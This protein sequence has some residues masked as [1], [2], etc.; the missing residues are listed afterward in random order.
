M[1]RIEELRDY[2]DEVLLCNESMK[3]RRGGFVHLYGVAQASAVLAKKRG[4]DQ[5]LAVMAAMLHDIHSYKYGYTPEHG[6][7]GAVM[8]RDVLEHLQ[9]ADQKEIDII[10]E[11]IHSHSQ[12]DEVGS[13]YGEVL[14]DADVWQH[15]MYNPLFPVAEWE[16]KRYRA[17]LLEL[18]IEEE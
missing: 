12:K 5:E 3:V 15:C 6:P 10:C 13:V 17:V 9:I 7:K 4:L 1:N 14:K 16:Q 2:I 8:A 18:G 11:A